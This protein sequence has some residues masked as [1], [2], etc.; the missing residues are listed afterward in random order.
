MKTVHATFAS[1]DDHFEL[2]PP[3]PGRAVRALGLLVSTHD[4]ASV[5]LLADPGGEPRV[6]MPAVYVDGMRSFL[7]TLGRRHAFVTG[8]GEALVARVVSGGPTLQLSLLV[9]YEYAS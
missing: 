5:Q 6:L 1:T 7:L 9:W 4:Q 8:P 3:Q 2:A